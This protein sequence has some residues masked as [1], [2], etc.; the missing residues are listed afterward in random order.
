MV[1]DIIDIISKILQISNSL[2]GHSKSGKA[3]FEK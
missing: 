2:N 3:N 1:R